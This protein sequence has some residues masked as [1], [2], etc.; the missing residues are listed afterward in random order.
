MKRNS[1]ITHSKRAQ[2][3][4]ASACLSLL[5]ATLPI[6]SNAQAQNVPPTTNAASASVPVANPDYSCS[7]ASPDFGDNACAAG[8]VV[9]ISP[10]IVAA[11]AIAVP[12][13]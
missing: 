3:T 7:F 1:M 11:A 6:S 9:L 13:V 5:L 10:F 2:R 12:M 4:L 8:E